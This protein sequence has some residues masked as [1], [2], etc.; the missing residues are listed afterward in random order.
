[1]WLTDVLSTT[2]EFREGRFYRAETATQ[3][4]EIPYNVDGVIKRRTLERLALHAG[5]I[6]ADW[7]SDLLISLIVTHH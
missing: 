1:M 7:A 4:R 2:T 3:S 5:H 6:A